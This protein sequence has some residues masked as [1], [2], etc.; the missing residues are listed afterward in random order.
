MASVTK[1]GALPLVHCRQGR[2]VRGGVAL[3][4]SVVVVRNPEQRT[5]SLLKN[6]LLGWTLDQNLPFLR[7]FGTQPMFT[8]VMIAEWDRQCNVSL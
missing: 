1:V 8:D 5:F 6:I 3:L 2:R 7:K 4:L